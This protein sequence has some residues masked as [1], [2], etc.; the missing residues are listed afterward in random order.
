MS[1]DTHSI[2]DDWKTLVEEKGEDA[3]KAAFIDVLPNDLSREEIFAECKNSFAG[4]EL[5]E[6]C[7]EVALTIRADCS[8]DE[9]KTWNYDHLEFIIQLS[10]KFV[11]QIP[12]N[13][14]NGLPEQLI[15]LVDKDKL[16]RPECS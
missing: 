15:I 14:L 2:I 8:S 12:M 16:Q 10:N 11:I 3:L 5:A 7:A 9:F 4:E 6:I 13:L 1:D